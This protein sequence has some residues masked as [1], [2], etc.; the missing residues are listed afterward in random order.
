MGG[1][2]GGSGAPGGY[3][4]GDWDRDKKRAGKY[5]F[6]MGIF[7]KWGLSFMA[8]MVVLGV[9]FGVGVFALDWF[10]AGRD[11]FGPENV[12]EQ[13]RLAYDRYEGL[14]ALAEQVCNFET[15]L[16][17]AE[18]T[19][20]RQQIESQ[21]LAVANN[22]S[23]VRAQYEAAYDD[24]FRAGLVGPRDLP[25]EAPALAEMQALVC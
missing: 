3:S 21:R 11:V 13:F 7:V 12:R 2:S 4:P 1:G 25:E 8:L 5:G 14:E 16:E 24:A 19:T 23:R 18:S 15:S 20:A 6:P 9:I 10:R 22:Y 17:T